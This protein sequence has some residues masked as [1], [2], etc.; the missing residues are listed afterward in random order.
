MSAFSHTPFGWATWALDWLTQSV[1][2]NH[3]NYSS[4][5]TSVAHWGLP[6]NGGRAGLP[7]R[8]I[9]LDQPHFNQSREGYGRPATEYTRQVFARQSGR[10]SQ[11]FAENRPDEA[12]RPLEGAERNYRQDSGNYSRP[13]FQAYNRAEAPV[14]ARQQADARSGYG[15]GFYGH[16]QQSYTGRPATAYASPQ[17]NWRSAAP[18][19]QRGDFAQRS[20]LGDRSYSPSTGRDFA[21][22]KQAH[23]G[24]IHLFGGGR[25]A[26]KSYSYGGGHAPK[27]Y[28]GGKSYHG[29]GKSFSKGHS[30]GGGHSGGHHGGG[31]HHN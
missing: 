19:P 8:P 21:E 15:S 1:L 6:S 28:S 24:G 26:E 22:P 17:Q 18:G 23:S 11:S 20:Y 13:G 5:S 27:S 16:S 7:R 30:G 9:P 12:N 29:G 10:N 3:S 25:N 4:N 2:F 31:H 14:T